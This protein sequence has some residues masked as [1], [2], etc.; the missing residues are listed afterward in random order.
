[1][2][3]QITTH[4][5]D[6]K[7]RLL[8]QYQGKANIEALISSLSS[9]Q[10]QDLEDV[11]F[12]ISTRLNID[13]SVGVQLNNIG[14]IIGQPRNG[15]ND[16]TYRLFLKGKAGRNVSEGDIERVLSIWK[17]ITGGSVVQV[18]EIFPA[19]IELFSD[20]PVPDA[21]A[22]DAFDLMQDVVGAGIRVVS[23]VIGSDHPFGFE[24]R[25]S[26]F[27]FDSILSLG[28]NTSVTAFK[29]IDIGATFGAD[30]VDT[31]SVV[32]HRDTLTEANVLSVDSPT[33]L[34]L[35]ADIFTG[36]PE[37]YEVLYGLGGEIANQ[38]GA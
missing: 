24:G 5:E 36:T 7:A 25:P 30:G 8:F 13:T 32:T 28:N 12:D 19:N 15:Q 10:I 23:S 11:L 14:V 20:I 22:S 26:T 17:I 6:A 18:I 37:P 29:L 9:E 31:D 38:Q 27:G 34:T 21:L 35:D 3:T 16:A 2:I 33:Q 1:M 4:V